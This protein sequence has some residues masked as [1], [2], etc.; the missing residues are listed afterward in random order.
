[1]GCGTSNPEYDEKDIGKSKVSEPT[2]QAGPKPSGQRKE[3]PK[4]H[5][6]L[7]Q[8]KMISASSVQKGKC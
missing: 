6:S 2:K 5:H 8:S 7:P 4:D 3:L 1:M